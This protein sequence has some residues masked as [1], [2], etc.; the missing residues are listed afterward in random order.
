MADNLLDDPDTKDG[1]DNHDDPLIGDLNDNED[2]SSL[3]DAG[4]PELQDEAEAGDQDDLLA[5]TPTDESEH[6]L[7]NTT[8]DDPV[9]VARWFW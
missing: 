6:L 3:L 2:D 7:D 8:E 4:L 9:S 1:A 5:T